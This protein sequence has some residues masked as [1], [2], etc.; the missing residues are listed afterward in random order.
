M[1]KSPTVTLSSGG[2]SHFAYYDDDNL[3]VEW[4]DFGP[5][6]PYESANMLRFAV[7][8]YRR[9]AAILDPNQ[10]P[11][12]PEGLLVLL[13]AN[14]QTYFQVRAFALEHGISFTASVDFM[15]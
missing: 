2:G 9:L 15:P 6:A 4:Y 12:D 10:P 8:E 14:F 11:P 13:Q 5:E 1:T 3:V 7:A